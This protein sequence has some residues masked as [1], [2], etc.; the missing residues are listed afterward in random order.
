MLPSYLLWWVPYASANGPR[1]SLRLLDQNGDLWALP[2]IPNGYSVKIACDEDAP[3]D[4]PFPS[5]IARVVCGVL[6]VPECPWPSAADLDV[7]SGWAALQAHSADYAG[8]YLR[9]YASRRE[10]VG[11]QSRRH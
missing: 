11:A 4:P 5:S 3:S 6:G 2:M 7:V 8:Q 9:D 1:W 10:P